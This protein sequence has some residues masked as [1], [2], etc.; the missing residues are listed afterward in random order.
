MVAPDGVLGPAA[1]IECLLFVADGPVPITNL[2][3]A[4]DLPP[5][6]VEAAL[7]ALES[8]CETRGLRLQRWQDRVQL[9]TAP[10]AAVYIER[11]LGIQAT[12]RLTHAA[13]ETLAIV[14]YQQ[15]ATRPQIEGV[16]GVNSDSVI[17]SLLAKDLVEEIGRSEG[18]GRP[19]LYRTTPEFLQYFGLSSLAELPPLT[20]PAAG[21]A[22]P[23]LSSS[24]AGDAAAG[25][26]DGVSGQAL[27]DSDPARD[28]GLEEGD[29]GS[30]S[31]DVGPVEAIVDESGV[32][33]RTSSE[34][35]QPED[36]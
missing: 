14:A 10:A 7:A 9:T 17:K 30:A 25:L 16:R 22:P 36:R 4:L 26:S 12:V 18:V 5:R 13:L 29:L 20:L 34:K 1:L 2:A 6:E 32:E 33:E 11:F 8:A 23:T 3:Q 24:P 15:P 35:F 27:N 19:I 21:L 28:Q 31:H